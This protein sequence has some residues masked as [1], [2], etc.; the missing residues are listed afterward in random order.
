LIERLVEREN[1][2]GK[3]GRAGFYHY[4]SEG[5]KRLWDGLA[6]IVSPRDQQPAVDEV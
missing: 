2:P 5:R 4:P 1:R 3:K 6:D